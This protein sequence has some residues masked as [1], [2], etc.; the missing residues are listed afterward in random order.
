MSL[1]L[2]PEGIHYTFFST[3][4]G[5]L[6]A[7]VAAV[8]RGKG[9]MPHRHTPLATPPTTYPPTPHSTPLPDTF[10][11]PVTRDPSLAVIATETS[12]SGQFAWH[13]HLCIHEFPQRYIFKCFATNMIKP[14]N[15]YSGYD[16]IAQNT[17]QSVSG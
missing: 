13:L 6:L 5:S 7:Q 10:I 15:Y 3:L 1:F 2:A 9:S 8:G 16:E 12:S 14:R 11:L 17:C 4:V